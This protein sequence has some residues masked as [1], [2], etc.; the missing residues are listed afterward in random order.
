MPEQ[1]SARQW[2]MVH[3]RCTLPTHQ[4]FAPEHVKQQAGFALI[5][6]RH[7]LA[8][9]GMLPGEAPGYFSHQ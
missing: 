8:G 5:S 4:H 6:Y 3:Q 1:F 2:K 9:E 7:Q